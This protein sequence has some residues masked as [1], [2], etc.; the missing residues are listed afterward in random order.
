MLLTHIVACTCY[1][2]FPT[3]NLLHALSKR[4]SR[5]PRAKARTRSSG[6]D[7]SQGPISAT[8]RSLAQCAIDSHPPRTGPCLLP[9]A[10][11]H[12]T[13]QQA[14]AFASAVSILA[15]RHVANK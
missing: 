10:I 12:A 6:I 14:M 15:D 4:Y 13:V 11:S 8:T 1:T 5:H 9:A 2:W 3:Y 7:S